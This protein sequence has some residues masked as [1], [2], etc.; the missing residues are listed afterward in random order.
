MASFEAWKLASRAEAARKNLETARLIWIHRPIW[1]HEHRQPADGP[2]ICKCC[3][4]RHAIRVE[5]LEHID[6]LIDR[7]TGRR[8]VRSQ[9]KDKAG[10]DALAA[11]AERI[12]CPIRC[13]RK[14]LRVILDREHRVI[15][16][17]GGERGG[18]STVEA[19][20][21]FDRVLER[22]GIG[23]QF[24]WV[25]KTRKKALAIG[26]KKLVKGEL[27]DRWNRPIIPAALVLGYPRGVQHDVP[28]LLVDG[29]EI[30]FHHASTPDGDNLKGEP[31]VAVVIDEGCTVD[32]QANWTQC[33]MRITDAN[34]QLLTATT[35]II[36][37][38]LQKEVR[39]QGKSYDDLDLLEPEDAAKV[40]TVWTSLSQPDNPWLSAE[41][42][43]Q[44]VKALNG[45]EL[46]IRAHI[47]GEWVAI[48]RLLWRHFDE[49]THL[50]E[51]PWRDI[52]DWGLVPITKIAAAKFFRGTSSDLTRIGGQDFNV[53][54]HNV[55]VIQVGVPQ[56]MDSS[57]RRNWIVFVEDHVQK[58][59]TVTELAAFLQAEAG[60]IRKLPSNY[61]AALA[62]ACDPS[63]AHK[64]PHQ[65]HGL[66]GATTLAREMVRHG[67]DCRPCHLSDKGKAMC[68]P[69]IDRVSLM[70]KLMSDRVTTP[71][72]VSWPRLVIHGSRAPELV[73]SFK[74]QIADDRG[75]PLKRSSTMSDTI[76]GPTDALGY[77]IWA[78]FSDHE[79]R[80]TKPRYSSMAAPERAAA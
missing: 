76:S 37:H 61:F 31:P 44:N 47:Y 7:Q 14:Q 59:G 38:Y 51:G 12:D 19:E 17:F 18:K 43:A 70:H 73:Y 15:G 20:W 65:T 49:V 13:S 63:G 16:V 80:V 55:V 21:F 25:S 32:H 22:G 9:L 39:E 52:A 48:G 72:G 54:P 46:K 6:V 69:I 10:F 23:A 5:D 3:N 77:V 35:P 40:S 56:G 29:T 30:W 2:G 4:S 66:K 53:D 27:T 11:Q 34:G 64:N 8:W 28:L 24:W 45:D 36:G 42:I 60:R 62:I 74:T 67:F 68:P 58:R 41:S 75:A 26:L 33:L 78:L 1:I 79:W 71:E 57:D 50:R